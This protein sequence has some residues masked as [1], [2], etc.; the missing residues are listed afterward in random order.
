MIRPFTL[1]C[2]VS[3]FG[4]GLYLYQSKHQAQVLDREIMRTIKQTEATRERTG[5]LRAEWALLN[6]PDRL[7][8]LAKAHTSL[9]TL[10]P[11]QFV[12]LADLGARLPAPVAQ[13]QEQLPLEAEPEEPIAAPVAQA[14]PAPTSVA[15]APRETSVSVAA[16]EAKPKSEPKVEPKPVAVAEA[17]PAQRP[18]EKPPAGRPTTPVQVAAETAAPVRASR[19]HPQAEIASTEATAPGTVGAAVMRAM[20]A[21][22]G[23]GYVQA[24]APAPTRVYAQ[25]PAYAQP[26]YAPTAY[27]QPAY[28]QPAYAPP[29]A[30]MLGGHTALPPPVPFASR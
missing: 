11:T 8:E 6:E 14:A 26:A 1:I 5:M 16:V 29:S 27:A 24:A 22:N 4:A 10:K 28:A 23:G 3:A 2:M 7:A 13:H 18:V 12:A 15:K 9:Q 20:R 19:P 25:Q 17:K 21:Q 30:S